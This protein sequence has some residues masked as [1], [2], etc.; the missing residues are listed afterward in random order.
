MPDNPSLIVDSAVKS[1][2]DER[3]ILYTDVA[4]G[5]APFD[6]NV[7]YDGEID[8]GKKLG[9]GI[10]KIPIKNQGA[11]GSCGGQAEAYGAGSLAVLTQGGAYKEKSA[12]F[13][14]APIHAPGGGTTGRALSDRAHASGWGLESLTPSY[15]DGT[16][17]S[18]A[19]M[20]RIQDIFPD[21]V[22]EGLKNKAINYVLLPVDIDTIAQAIRDYKFA[23]IGVVGSNNGSWRSPDPIPPT[24]FEQ[25]WYHWV[26]GLKAQ[27]RQGK[28]AIGFPNSWGRDGVGD[29][30]WQWLNEDWFNTR[31]SNDKY[32]V[33]PLFEPRAYV[34][35]S[36]P[37]PDTFHYVF[38]KDLQYGM[39]DIDVVQLQT[40]LRADGEFPNGVPYNTHFG[41]ITRTSV[42]KFQIKY[43]ISNSLSQGFGRCGPKTRAKLNELFG[44]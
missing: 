30:G 4:Y 6:W 22:Q 21:A 26:C 5:A 35:N 8:L 10:Y 15:N 28:K 44:N 9:V 36:V 16:A 41:P 34:S 12:K 40:A 14:Y 29:L 2:H 20:E 1:P 3:D 39:N 18:E 7:G 13:T 27:V 11:S 19:F 31:L 43:N 32:G 42:Q 17:P 38:S 25:H 37:L 24:D 33:L 23:R